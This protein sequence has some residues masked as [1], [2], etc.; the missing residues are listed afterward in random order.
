ML[1]MLLLLQEY[2]NSKEIFYILQSILLSLLNPK[3]NLIFT[4]T[5]AT[6]GVG[7]AFWRCM[8]IVVLQQVLQHCNVPERHPPPSWSHRSLASFGFK[9]Y[10]PWLENVSHAVDGDLANPFAASLRSASFM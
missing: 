5:F 10:T 6:L 8:W 2:L 9:K 4:A 1:Q 3:P 7:E